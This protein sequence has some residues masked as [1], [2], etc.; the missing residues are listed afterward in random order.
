MPKDMWQT[1]RGVRL[2]QELSNLNKPNGGNSA[3]S[4]RPS[5]HCRTEHH[6][7]A[8]AWLDSASRILPAH[9][10]MFLLAPAGIG[11]LIASFWACC[12]RQMPLSA[13]SSSN[14]FFGAQNSVYSV[15]GFASPD[16]FRMLLS[17]KP[18]ILFK[19]LP[20]S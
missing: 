6:S 5:N 15:H 9:K 11:L 16:W 4:I 12:C 2:L 19:V 14:N 7:Q 17:G 18:C 1:T 13:V 3:V 20:T 10:G 8:Y